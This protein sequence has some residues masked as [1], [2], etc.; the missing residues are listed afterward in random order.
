[1]GARPTDSIWR[2]HF[3]NTQIISPGR[4]LFRRLHPQFE[5]F[6]EA[7]CSDGSPFPH[8]LKT[9]QD[10]ELSFGR[11]RT[12]SDVLERQ[13]RALYDTNQT[14]ATMIVARTDFVTCDQTFFR[15]SQLS[16]W[17]EPPRS[18][19]RKMGSVLN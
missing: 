10:G 13:R 6:R 17:D 2:W 16:S 19:T 3:A 7:E 12:E 14:D 4:A 9:P 5:F 11:A 1:M 8:G 18:I 15:A